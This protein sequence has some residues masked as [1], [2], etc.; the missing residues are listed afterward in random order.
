[1]AV[2]H[3]QELSLHILWFPRYP[4]EPAAC[5]GKKITT[6][7]TA[8]EHPL[9]SKVVIGKGRL[10]EFPTF[11]NIESIHFDLVIIS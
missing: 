6:A 9:G 8:V 3:G 5:Q 7:S 11:P 2:T 4:S 10:I 1:M